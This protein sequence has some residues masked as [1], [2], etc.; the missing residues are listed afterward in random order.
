[1]PLSAGSA[2]RH[3]GLPRDKEAMRTSHRQAVLLTI[4][5]SVVAFAAWVPAYNEN[6]GSLLSSAPA[7]RRGQNEGVA[8]APGAK[9]QAS[10]LAAA[11]PERPPLGEPRSGLFGSQSWQPPAPKIAPAPVAPSAPPMPYRF[12]GKLVQDGKVQIFLSK[13]D[14]IIPISEGQTIDGTYRVES[15]TPER[16]TLIYLP[17]AHKERIPVQG[18]PT[19]AAQAQTSGPGTVPART[20]IGPGSLDPSIQKPAAGRPARVLWEGPPRVKL[21]SEFSVSLRVT[22]DRPVRA[23][24][25]Q[26]RFDPTLLDAVTIRPGRFFESPSA[27]FNYRITSDGSIFVSASNNTPAP[28]SDAELLVLVVKPIKP[29]AIA[30]VS[31]ASLDV[32]GAAGEMIALD[33]V[34]PFKTPIAR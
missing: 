19:A 14:L 5:G 15:I 33:S 25:M 10:A 13:Q 3:P 22:S 11:L 23:S 24:L 31:I 12:A 34:T 17:L 9:D 28:A 2:E 16:V 32:Q 1:M 6:L 8:T 20:V 21:G 4:L 7:Q 29:V 26:L 30:E 27:N 18:S